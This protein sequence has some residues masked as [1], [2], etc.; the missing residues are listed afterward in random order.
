M[1]HLKYMHRCLA[2]AQKGAGYVAPNPMVGAVLVHN[3]SIIGEGWHKQYGS[4]HAE[5]NCIESVAAED[6]HLIKDATMYVNL[7]P[8]AHWGKTPPCANRL[9]SDGIKHVV[10]ANVDPFAQV[11]GR[12]IAILEEAGVSVTTGIAADIGTWVNRRFFCTH[13]HK[14]PYIILKWAQTADGYMAPANKERIAITNHQ[15]N[16]LVHKWRSEEGAI[17]VGTQTAL[18]DNP[19]LNARNWGGHNPL[20]IAIDKQLQIPQHYN[21]LDNS[22]PTWII[23]NHKDEQ[24]GTT[25][26]IQLQEGE[27]I[28]PAILNR[29]HEAN[30]LSLIVEGGPKLLQSFID[31][32]LWDEARVLRG[33][34]HIGGGIAGPQLKDARYCGETRA[35]G[36][37]ITLYTHSSSIYQPPSKD[38]LF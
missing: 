29:L 1:S 13:T 19:Q 31:N 14:R 7:E 6:K 33:T 38:Y 21:L 12:G 26:Y 10:I 35:T 18:I 37:T 5:V 23:N 16:L 9:V 36:D 3:D 22:Q 27:D 17:L 2:L 28:I 34:T 25:K 8:C 11:A 4:H 15:T 32:N 24:T 30:I 20:R